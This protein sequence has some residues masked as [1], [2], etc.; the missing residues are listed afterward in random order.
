MVALDRA[1]PLANPARGAGDQPT[2]TLE[3]ALVG[4]VVVALVGG[5]SSPVMS[6]D[7]CDFDPM[8]P[9]GPSHGG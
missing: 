3:I 9:G 4:M 8:A 1:E 2:L 6:Q 5:L 7:E